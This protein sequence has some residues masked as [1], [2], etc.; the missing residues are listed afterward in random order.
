MYHTRLSGSGTYASVPQE[1]PGLKRRSR[2]FG[3]FVDE[4][5]ERVVKMQSAREL[6]CERR[7]HYRVLSHG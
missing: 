6:D 1:L 3:I 2:Y 5:I 7:S 4:V